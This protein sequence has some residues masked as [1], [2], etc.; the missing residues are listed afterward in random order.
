[1]GEQTILVC[2]VCGKPAVETA[3]IRVGTRSY[4]KDYC[5]AHLS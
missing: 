1:M 2:D 4:V 5:S 3:T